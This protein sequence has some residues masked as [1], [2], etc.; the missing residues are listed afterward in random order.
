M[1]K[2]TLAVLAVAL[3]SSACGHSDPLGFTS[4]LA[5]LP[6]TAVIG[7]SLQERMA[8]MDSDDTL[9]VIV[10]FRQNKGLAKST[11]V[12]LQ[13]MGLKGGYFKRL[14]VAGVVA[15]RE[16]IEQLARRPDVRSLWHN[17]ELQYDN[18]DARY[19]SSVD[20][21]QAA[22]ELR[23]ASGEPITGKGV[24]IL[25]NDSGID[26]LHPDLMNKVVANAIGH[27][28]L[29]GVAEDEM[30]P[31]TPTECAT[32][33]NSDF[34]GSHG[35]HVSGI[36]AGDG[37][38][39]GG[40]YAG[41]AKGASLIGYGSGA[42][43]L[44]LDTL[45]GFDYA[46]QMLDEHP[47]YNLRI[48][49]NS[50]GATG[51]QGTPFNPEDPTNI[52][53]KILADRGLIVVFSAGNSGS[54]P[55]SI[56]GNF[57]KAPWIMIAA[58]GEK[59]GLLAPSSSR[60]TL[61][62]PVYE[63]EVDGEKFTVEDRPTVVTAGTNIVSARAV[64]ADP[65]LPL[66]LVDD[67]QNPQFTPQQVP[68]YTLKTGTSMAAPHLA[69]LTALLLEANPALNWR[70]IKSIFKSTATN[71]PG[72]DAWEAGAGFANV[73]AALAMALNLRTDYGSV[74]H[75]LRE[76]NAQIP[77]GERVSSEVHSIA[78]VTAGPTG[79]VQFEVGADIALVSA[80]Y[81]FQA[82]C[83]CSVVLIDPNGKERRSSGSLPT[84]AP[85]VS[86]TATG[87]AGTWTLTVRGLRSLSGV[88]LDPTGMTNGASAPAT[89]N[90]T[91]DLYAFKPAQGLADIANHPLQGFIEAAVKERLMDGTAS[92]FK[93]NADLLR[94]DFAE[95]LM[96]WGVRQTRRHANGNLYADIPANQARVHAASEAITRSGALILSRSPDSLPLLRVTDKFSP[97]AKVTR[98]EIAS[99]LV[100]AIGRQA[101]AEAHTG[102]M[103]APDD[104]GNAVE[105]ADAADIDPALRGHVQEALNLKIISAEFAGGQARVR[106][107]SAVTRADYAA[108]A[109]KTFA[110]VTFP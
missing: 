17:D 25:V 33:C 13:E 88:V 2:L 73:E 48:V 18:E 101:Q 57:K 82:P 85:R 95:Y 27:T 15:T 16:Q 91:L 103:T 12:S 1:K 70:E 89:V 50:F 34:G 68:F 45:G 38:A 98:E 9:E 19:L 41:A 105:V 108:A 22:P 39:S 77:I 11:A 32:P 5:V 23:N 53:T 42:T 102:A 6:G 3:L 81:A 56:T 54:G 78:F 52:V 37:T 86:A 104:S 49:T 40:K 44:V 7:A 106:P 30:L 93:P 80:I 28:N 64:A 65:F 97:S 90:I 83:S 62:D 87:I 35:S 92:G 20:A 69:G 24:A 55:D 14:P 76:F 72:Y 26:G 84:L 4:K 58:N 67:V 47:E 110:S 99:A 74:N 61:V 21:A 59:S 79:S 94:A 75:A 10:T 66:D 31:F 29:R 51:D 63:V 100:Q 60:G 36:A 96:A 71:M 46:L 109:V 107:K 43:L 8:L